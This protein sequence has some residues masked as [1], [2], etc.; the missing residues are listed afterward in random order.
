MKK[1]ILALSI[2][3][4]SSCDVLFPTYTFKVVGSGQMNITFL[5]DGGLNSWSGSSQ[6]FKRE[7]GVDEVWAM[8][9][10]SKNGTGCKVEAYFGSELI[11]Q[12]NA[13]GYGVASISGINE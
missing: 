11:K 2:I 6:E 10:Q 7:M 1:L 3:A 13:N 9:A 8:S 4:L 12:A 5:D